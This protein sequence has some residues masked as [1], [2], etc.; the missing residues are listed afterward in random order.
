MERFQ[1]KLEPLCFGGRLG[2]LGEFTWR[3][4]SSRDTLEFLLVSKGLWKSWRG[5]LME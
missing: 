5:S 4:E 1:W 3:R 2:E